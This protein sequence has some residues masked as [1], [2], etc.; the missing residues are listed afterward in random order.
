M[1]DKDFELQTEKSLVIPRNYFERYA[2]LYLQHGTAEKAWQAVEAELFI[3]TGGNRFLSLQSF[4]VAQS[5]YHSGERG[6]AVVL[7]IET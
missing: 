6:R 1:I 4:Q 7:K 5:R 2:Y 3:Q